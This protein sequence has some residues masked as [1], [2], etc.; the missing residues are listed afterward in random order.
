[1]T[2]TNPVLNDGEWE[3]QCRFI[4]DLKSS[5]WDYDVAWNILLIHWFTRAFSSFFY[6]NYTYMIVFIFCINYQLSYTDLSAA[7]LPST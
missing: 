3:G 6:L 4:L 5:H 7:D 2:S 1:M